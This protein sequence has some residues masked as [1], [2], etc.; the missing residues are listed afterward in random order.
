METK[1]ENP[2]RPATRWSVR[3]SPSYEMVGTRT[4]PDIVL[5]L[6]RCYARVARH[7]EEVEKYLAA[8]GD[9]GWF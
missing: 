2:E 6:E 5:G 9:N 7:G 3:L 4:R 8:V 1:I